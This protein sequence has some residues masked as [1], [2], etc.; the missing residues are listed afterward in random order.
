LSGKSD[1]KEYIIVQIDAFTKYVYLF[2]TFSLDANTCI[3]AII[4]SIAIFGVPTRLIADQ[5]RSFTGIKF[6]QFCS[7]QK[8]QLHLIERAQVE[9]TVKLK[10]S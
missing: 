5:G 2:H 10:G 3:N 8:L 1:R 9:P 4:S 7:S 6:V